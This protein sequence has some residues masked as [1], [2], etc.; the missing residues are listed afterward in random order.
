MYRE[1]HAMC[2]TEVC[3]TERAPERLAVI[4]KTRPKCAVQLYRE[5]PT[6]LCEVQ[7]EASKISRI[8]DQ[9]GPQPDTLVAAPKKG[10]GGE[11][12]L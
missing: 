4:V 5:R 9:P 6:V 1:R 3:C 10:G 8:R 12:S 11:Q 2:N 7:R